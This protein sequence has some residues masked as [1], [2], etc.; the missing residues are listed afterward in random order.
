MM[1][2]LNWR[3]L[4]QT[5]K[6]ITYLI[7][8]WLR[9]HQPFIMRLGVIMWSLIFL[10]IFHA[11]SIFHFDLLQPSIGFN[12]WTIVLSLPSKRLVD[13]AV[14]CILLCIDQLILKARFALINAQIYD[15]LLW[16]FLNGFFGT[17]FF[18]LHLDLSS[19]DLFFCEVDAI[20]RK[21]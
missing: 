13:C 7:D 10:D 19:I 6:L 1:Y 5:S 21:L 8:T 12:S 9:L 2:I 16:F 11:I 15:S 3:I 18:K 14:S 20:R 4:N 17:L